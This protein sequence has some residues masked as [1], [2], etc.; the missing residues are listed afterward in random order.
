M[1]SSK[2]LIKKN[3]CLDRIFSNSERDI[4]ESKETVVEKKTPK[5]WKGDDWNNDLL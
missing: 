1:S 5:N 4:F 3:S 2:T